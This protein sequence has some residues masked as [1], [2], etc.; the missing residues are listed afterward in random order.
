MSH[1][2]PTKGYISSDPKPLPQ[3]E[4]G[5]KR[6]PRPLRMV[7][8]VPTK[9]LQYNIPIKKFDFTYDHKVSKNLKRNEVIIQVDCVGL[10]G[11]DWKIK[12]GFDYAY[13]NSLVDLNTE[14]CLGIEFSGEII[15]VSEKLDKDINFQVGRKVMGIYYNAHNGT[16]ETCIKINVKEHLVLAKPDVLSTEVAAGTIFNL[17]TILQ[18]FRNILYKEVDNFKANNSN[19][20]IIGGS[21]N[22]SVMLLKYLN[23]LVNVKNVTVVA[24]YDGC[25]FLK[26]IFIKWEENN[27]KFINYYSN[28]H[29]SDIMDIVRSYGKYRYV[30]DFIGGEEYL[31]ISNELVKRNGY[32]ITTVGSV[33]SNYSVDTYPETYFGSSVE[34]FKSLASSFWKFYYYKFQFDFAYDEKL[35][36]EAEDLIQDQS[37]TNESTSL[38]CFLGTVYD[39]KQYNEAFNDLKS[40]KT[41]GK[42]VMKIEK[43]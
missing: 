43:F 11:I 14:T 36:M 19:I 35:L 31:S 30:F 8:N 33:Q 27:W 34:S 39:W 41:K 24:S 38:T 42:L 28:D 4:S 25:D 32:F 29:K 21:T 23:K 9:R 7:K 22:T 40:Q 3:Q 26:S 5:L 1:L 15:A 18:I 10:N 6:Q 17:L 2:K 12:N 16:M 20:L 13:D 37:F